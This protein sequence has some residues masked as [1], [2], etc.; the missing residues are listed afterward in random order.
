MVRWLDIGR[1]TIRLAR[2]RPPCFRRR[3][4]CHWHN[5]RRAV[6]YSTGRP[7]LNALP[8]LTLRA[9][10]RVGCPF[11]GVLLTFTNAACPA[12]VGREP[13]VRRPPPSTKR[14]GTT[15]TR[16]HTQERRAGSVGVL[17]GG[18]AEE[19]GA[20][21]PGSARRAGNRGT[22]ALLRAPE[23]CPSA[24]G[25]QAHKRPASNAARGCPTHINFDRQTRMVCFTRSQRPLT[26]P[27]GGGGWGATARHKAPEI[28]CRGHTWE[29]GGRGET[30]RKS[31]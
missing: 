5:A 29:G 18:R 14:R 16:E 4:H 22:G 28:Y 12:I 11:P 27:L 3:R 25:R 9:S 17:G 6:P 23:A 19:N 20:Q 8:S 10:R 1:S 30:T 24:P 2:T 13:V 21:R 15:H 7:P 31:T 26:A